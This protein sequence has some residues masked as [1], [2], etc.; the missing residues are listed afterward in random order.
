MKFDFNTYTKEYV[1][2]EKIKSYTVKTTLIKQK[3]EEQIDDLKWYHMN[4]YIDNEELKEFLEIKEELSSNT[5]IILVIGIGGSYSGTKAIFDCLSNPFSKT[6]PKVMF[7]GTTLS[8]DYLSELF[9]YLKDKRVSVIA[10]SKSG[11]TMEVLTTLSITLSYMKNKYSKKEIRRRVF[12]IT[13]I[14]KGKLL[15]ISKTEG[16]RTY[17]IPDE[18]GGRY[19]LFTPVTLFPMALAGFDI[20]S[21]LK[22]AKEGRMHI[23]Y[24]SIY[25]MIR[26]IMYESEKVV[27]AITIFNP[28]YSSLVKYLIQLFS[29][30]EGKN[31]KG[32]LPIELVYPRDLHS[33]EQFMIE[34]TPLFFKTL[35]TVEENSELIAPNYDLSFSKIEEVLIKSVN[36]VHVENAIP[37]NHIKL[38]KMNEY[39]IGELLMFFMMSAAMSGYLLDI[40]PFDQPGVEHY[41]ARLKDEL[42]KLK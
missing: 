34:G 6:H 29:E 39:H 7:I 10:I 22:G 30:T 23:N 17:F 35:I 5:D 28:K 16:Y 12:V 15:E 24:A 32:L 41:K 40:D 1:D 8:S 4:E 3:F 9:T 11:N 31:Q 42:E 37:T 26:S 21:F 18:I 19:S 14:H 33:L 38:E 2:S 36:Q 20:I 25:A 13:N 27:E